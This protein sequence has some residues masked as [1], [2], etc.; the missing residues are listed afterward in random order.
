M[1]R[2][3]P[4]FSL[5]VV[6]NSI[7]NN[8]W[9]IWCKV[10]ALRN[11]EDSLNCIWR[12]ES[13]TSYRISGSIKTQSSWL[14]RLYHHDN[15]YQS[16][17]PSHYLPQPSHGSSFPE[18]GRGKSHQRCYAISALK[19]S[20]KQILFIN[21]SCIHSCAFLHTSS[22]KRSGNTQTESPNQTKSCFKRPSWRPCT[23]YTHNMIKCTLV[24]SY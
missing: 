13:I 1:Y 21:F 20:K 15:G 4:Q 8:A 11:Q 3:L 2:C 18:T 5:F 19:V 22:Y 23:W 12:P 9:S 14:C 16:T 24:Q 17:R 6:K 10:L 7:Y